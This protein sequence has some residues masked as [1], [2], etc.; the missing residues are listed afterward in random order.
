MKK[1]LLIVTILATVIGLTY[2]TYAMSPELRQA[3][4]EE[5]NLYNHEITFRGIPWGTSYSETLQ[6]LSDII[7]PET[8]I[9]RPCTWSN[10][11]TQTIGFE[12]CVGDINPDV[13]TTYGDVCYEVDFVT[14]DIDPELS[15]AFDINYINSFEVA[16]HP[17]KTMSLCFVDHDLDPATEPVFCRGTYSFQF[18]DTVDYA[19]SF[20][21]YS[22]LQQKLA[23]TYSQFGCD[24]CNTEYES[25]YYTDYTDYN[26]NDIHLHYNFCDNTCMLSLNYYSSSIL[27]YG[28]MMTTTYIINLHATWDTNG[29]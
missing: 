20:S 18:L 25:A 9:C 21:I 16:G 4:A 23:A 8:V 5:Q 12:A 3:Q 26:S 22:D 11:M 24:F 29:L 13:L 14:P 28:E 27:T 15:F 1:L 7:D 2:P 10:V 19:S 6:M 17:V